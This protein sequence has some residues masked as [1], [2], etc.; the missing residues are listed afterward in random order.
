MEVLVALKATNKIFT[1]QRTRNYQMDN[2]NKFYIFQIF[3]P[4]V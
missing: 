1:G 2:S 4:A 3:H